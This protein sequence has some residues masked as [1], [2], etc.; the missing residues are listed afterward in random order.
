MYHTTRNNINPST[1][2]ENK[3]KSKSHFC[4]CRSIGE[5]PLIPSQSRAIFSTN[6]PISLTREKRHDFNEEE[7]VIEAEKW[8]STTL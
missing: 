5:N 4:S 6:D 7:W 1:E 2:T 3:E 8:L